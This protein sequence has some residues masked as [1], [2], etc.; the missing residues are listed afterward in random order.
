MIKKVPILK[1][2]RGGDGRYRPDRGH[3]AIDVSRI[4]HLEGLEGWQEYPVTA[5]HLDDGSRIDV[6]LSISDIISLSRQAE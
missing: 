3:G 4:T 1:Q 5:V 6:L 2:Y